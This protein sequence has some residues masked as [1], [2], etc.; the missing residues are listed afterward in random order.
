[1]NT[2]IIKTHR[3][4]CSTYDF[5]H[6]NGLSNLSDKLFGY[7][8]EAEDDCHQIERL[9]SA[10]GVKGLE[11][12]FLEN[13]RSDYD[14]WVR[15]NLY[16]EQSETRV[17]YYKVWCDEPNKPEGISADKHFE[18]PQVMELFSYLNKLTG[19]EYVVNLETFD[20]VN[21]EMVEH[22]CLFDNR[23]KTI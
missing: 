14:I 12:I 5:V 11:V 7:G 1:M 15:H 16:K 13:I 21:Q 18:L 20:V 6:E 17:Q 2:E 4:Y 19:L 10:T 23:V 22:K 9:I 3:R 8:W